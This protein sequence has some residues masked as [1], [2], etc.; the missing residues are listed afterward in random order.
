MKHSLALL[1][2][3][4]LFLATSLNKSQAQLRQLP[5]PYGPDV[6][7]TIY[8]GGG[9]HVPYIDLDAQR[10]ARE[11]RREVP[12][13]PKITGARMVK[14]RVHFTFSSGGVTTMRYN[15]L[16]SRPGKTQVDDIRWYT[17]RTEEE[18]IINEVPLPDTLYWFRVQAVGKNKTLRGPDGIYRYPLTDFVGQMFR[19]PPAPSIADKAKIT[20]KYSDLLVPST[21]KPS[22][23]GGK[24]V[25]TSVRLIPSPIIGRHVLTKEPLLVLPA[26]MV[27][28]K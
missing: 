18:Y 2:F 27:P 15:I 25:E 22:P 20:G 5:A 1:A 19:T 13:D 23:F 16:W 9:D 3:L 21:T 24:R 6:P 17:G 28:R 12:Y 11:E 14:G 26:P 7:D 8:K 10:K 4:S